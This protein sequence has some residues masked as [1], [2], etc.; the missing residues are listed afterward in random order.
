[1]VLVR[2]IMSKKKNKVDQLDRTVNQSGIANMMPADR[3]KP[4]ATTELFDGFVRD[5]WMLAED[6]M[7]GIACS[8]KSDL[9]AVERQLVRM[10]RRRE[11]LEYRRGWISRFASYMNNEE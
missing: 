7:E 10:N 2:V 5:G 9:N 3:L 6:R 11:E 1:M 8:Y 4:D